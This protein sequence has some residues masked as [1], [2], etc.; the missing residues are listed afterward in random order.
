MESDILNT[1][2]TIRGYIFVTMAVI[3]IFVSI[4]IFQSLFPFVFS[5]SERLDNFLL[6]TNYKLFNQGKT[7]KV[8][9]DCIDI[10]A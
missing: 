5:F 8:I 2:E 9:N 6:D 4:K 7:K 1:L 3:V 10:L